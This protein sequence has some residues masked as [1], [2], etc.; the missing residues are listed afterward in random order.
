MKRFGTCTTRIAIAAVLLATGVARHASAADSCTKATLKGS[1]GALLTGTIPGVGPL[2][3]VAVARFDGAG[4]WSY[5]ETGN[6]NGS[7]F[8]GQHLWVPTRSPRTVAARPRIR[9]ATQQL[10]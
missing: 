7:V 8:V 10:W 6:V 2:V 5:T 1:Y 9:V 4:G 3:T